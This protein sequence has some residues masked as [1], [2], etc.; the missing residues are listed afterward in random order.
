[1][2][3]RRNDFNTTVRAWALETHGWTGR[4]GGWI[5]TSDFKRTIS[6]GWHGV[7]SSYR[8]EIL[9]WA[10]RRVTAFDS[11]KQMTE[12]TVS[13]YRP[14]IMP[15]NALHRFLADQYDSAQ[16]HRNDPRRA[17]PGAYSW[18]FA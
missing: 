13:T 9:D 14:T 15:R 7:F 5:Y 11:F 16:I 10:T 17:F 18:R 2:P 12:Q 4:Q 8:T 6:Q 3:D 1:M